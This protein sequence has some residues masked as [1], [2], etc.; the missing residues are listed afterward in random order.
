[1]REKS[2]QER[3]RGKMSKEEG[4]RKFVRN[5]DK[6]GKIEREREKF[7]KTYNIQKD[8]KKE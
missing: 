1:M 7:R 4:V 6:E 5:R 2:K 3:K 8:I